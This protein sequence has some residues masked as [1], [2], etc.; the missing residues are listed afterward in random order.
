MYTNLSYDRL[1]AILGMLQE[2]EIVERVERENRC[3]YTL[4]PKG[5]QLLRE[6]RRIRRLLHDLGLDL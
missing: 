1:T 5:Q 2:R 4:T 3:Y 6:L